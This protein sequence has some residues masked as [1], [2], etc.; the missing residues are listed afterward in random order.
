MY[1][2]SIYY[3]IITVLRKEEKVMEIGQIFTALIY[4]G[5][6]VVAFTTLFGIVSLM[7][8]WDKV[9]S[10]RS[11][12]M[13]SSNGRHRNNPLQNDTSAFY[14]DARKVQPR[15]DGSFGSGSVPGYNLYS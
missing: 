2:L 15:P 9:P 5:V 14:D 6:I 13:N 12:G 7:I 10:Q 1:H 3:G 8:M 4:A 11:G